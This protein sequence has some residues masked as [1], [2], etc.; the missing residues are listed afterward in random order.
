M[1]NRISELWCRM[2]HERATWPMHGK[3]TCTECLRE[4]HVAW[5]EVPRASEYADASL[6]HHPV[7]ASV[8]VCV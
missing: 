7:S 6:R 2:M 5:A 4:Y 8:D 1:W 3:Y